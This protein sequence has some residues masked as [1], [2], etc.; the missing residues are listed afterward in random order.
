M[1]TG[2]T[3]VLAQTYVATFA[4]RLFETEPGTPQHLAELDSYLLAT[5]AAVGELAVG[6]TADELNAHYM[7]GL[8]TA[9]GRASVPV[10]IPPLSW[11]DRAWRRQIRIIEASIRLPHGQLPNNWDEVLDGIVTGRIWVSD[12]RPPRRF[13]AFLRRS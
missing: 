3:P 1:A 9:A 11:D 12:P 5:V 6:S 2:E 13:S 8:A 7:H 10:I 4:H